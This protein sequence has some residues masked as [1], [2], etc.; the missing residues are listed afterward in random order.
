MDN[1]TISV[2]KINEKDRA[3][4]G[5]LLPAAKAKA[6]KAIAAY[7]REAGRVNVSELTRYLGLSR[8]TVRGLADEVLAEWR[9][10]IEGQTVAVH[11]W[12]EEVTKDIDAHPE[13]FDKDAIA[14]IRLKLSML[15]KMRMLRKALR[16]ENE[17][18]SQIK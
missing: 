11:K 7:V 1:Q 18:R 6:L 5:N 13:Q 10:E 8:P 9:A 14:R 3:A 17:E 2:N 16:K 15:D 4:D 12:C